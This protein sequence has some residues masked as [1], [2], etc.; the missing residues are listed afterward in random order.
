MSTSM[1]AVF[2]LPEGAAAD[3]DRVE[4][5]LGGWLAG[6]TRRQGRWD[7]P[8]V[9]DASLFVAT[10]DVGY[11]VLKVWFSS[12]AYAEDPGGIE[13]WLGAAF[14]AARALGAVYG[15]LARDAAQLEPGWLREN[16]LL[17]VLTE[18]WPLLE[19]TFTTRWGHPG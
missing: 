12:R 19:R 11:D 4:A 9:L 5:A 16:L 2:V 18:D 13:A 17:P 8:R 14:E 6:A 1:G 15:V 10:D 7:L 3:P